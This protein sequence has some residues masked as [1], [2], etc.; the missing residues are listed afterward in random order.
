MRELWYYLVI[1][2]MMVCVSG[3]TSP[4]DNATLATTPAPTETL[5]SLTPRPAVSTDLPD[6]DYANVPV[7]SP[8]EPDWMATN[9]SY[10]ARVALR[11]EAAREMYLG[12]GEVEGVLLSCHPT[13]LPSA[14]DGCAPA[15]RIVNETAI[16]D[17]LVDERE[18]R[19]TTTV[20][21]TREA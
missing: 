12:G 7:I 13:P 4:V 6:F 14:G 17:F 16:V 8:E 2:G 18:G 3:C 20:T 5:V 21:G 9:A 10:I 1:I 11:D 19:V 15:L